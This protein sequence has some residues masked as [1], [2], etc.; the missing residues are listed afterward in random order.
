MSTKKPIGPLGVSP[1]SGYGY[2]VGQAARFFGEGTINPK[3]FSWN[4]FF[5]IYPARFQG[6]QVS[7]YKVNPIGSFIYGVSSAVE[8]LGDEKS[9]AGESTYVYI[10]CDVDDGK[11]TSAEIKGYP[12]V[13]PLFEPEEDLAKQTKVRHF[14][15]FVKK[16]KPFPKFGNNLTTPVVQSS[17]SVPI[18]I[19]ACI[20][21]FR[22]V[23]ITTA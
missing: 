18:A 15:G 22:G 19:P 12:S 4:A 5:Q 20:N 2:V 8:G 1:A 17:F 13:K 21:G 10:E 7:S 16:S 9:V 14:L 23:L 6:N 11:V 3:F